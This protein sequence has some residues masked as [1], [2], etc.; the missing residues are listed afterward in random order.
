M[1]L[2]QKLNVFAFA[3]PIEALQSIAQKNQATDEFKIHYCMLLAKKSRT[4][5]QM[6]N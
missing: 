6:K 3:P 5:L 1:A 4:Y 2:L